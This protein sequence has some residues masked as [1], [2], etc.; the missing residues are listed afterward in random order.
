MSARYQV[1]SECAHV[2]VVDH[3]GVKA[4]HLLY[5]G[6]FL[7]DDVDPARLEFLV[8]GGFVAPE[9]KV[10]LAPN[11]AVEQD[12]RTGVDSVTTGRLQGRSDAEVEAANRAAAEKA[13]ADADKVTAD[14][15]VAE[16]RAAAQAKLPQD[17]SAPD[18][19]AS[20]EVWV[21]YL[22]KRGSNYD[23]VK[24]ADKADLRALAEQQK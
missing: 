4:T 3:S 10:A 23:D 11:A 16:R 17:G 13:K 19:R 21:E 14:A 12:P 9:G 8:D 20:Q 22:V 24:D 2:E 1:I 6:A 5:K 15:E 7:P 18:G